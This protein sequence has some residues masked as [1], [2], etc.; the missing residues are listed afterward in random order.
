MPSNFENSNNSRVSDKKENGQNR[1]T[2]QFQAKVARAV[3][4]HV[5]RK[6][7]DQCRVSLTQVEEVE[8]LLV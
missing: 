4:V 5:E 8:V 3:A 6:M 7:L 1:S 2:E